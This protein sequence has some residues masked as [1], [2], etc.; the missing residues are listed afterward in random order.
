M[1]KAKEMDQLSLENAK[2]TLTQVG[3]DAS[4]EEC[5]K[6]A[7]NLYGK[8]RVL[9]DYI[10]EEA[11]KGLIDSN[12]HPDA[13]ATKKDLIRRKIWELLREDLGRRLA[14]SEL[15]RHTAGRLALREAMRHIP[16][17][18][19]HELLGLSESPALTMM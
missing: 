6:F 13:L 10:L 8:N 5:R 9:H 11:R 14:A 15:L 1:M 16:I 17:E 18:H 7:A 4:L 19:L 2:C 3:I 12:P